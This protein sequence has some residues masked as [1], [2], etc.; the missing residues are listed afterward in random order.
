M[1]STMFDTIMAR[2]DAGTLDDQTPAPAARVAP[3]GSDVV[4]GATS[5]LGMT[6]QGAGALGEALSGGAVGA[7]LRQAG[8]GISERAAAA[9]PG[10]QLGAG[11]ADETQFNISQSLASSVPLSAAGALG[12]AAIGRGIGTAIG[13][14]GGPVGALVGGLLIGV[15]ESL[16]GLLLGESLGQVGIFVIFIAV[17]MLRP[18]GFFGAK[19]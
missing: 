17:L 16:G 3:T 2:M 12:G 11:Y 13:T 14:A 15:V 4:Q 9:A 5:G 6:V 18:Q 7:G 8:A 10:A 19:A 1:A